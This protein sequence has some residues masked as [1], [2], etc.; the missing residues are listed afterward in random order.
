MISP[1]YKK[2]DLDVIVPGKVKIVK[3]PGRKILWTARMIAFLKSNYSSLSN[4]QLADSLGLSV[5]TVRVQLYKMGMRRMDLVYWTKNQVN[6]L[7]SHYKE[8]GDKEL[9]EIF[10]KKWHKAKVWTHKHIEKKR[11]Y[12]ELKRSKLQLEAIHQRN[13]DS[14]RFLLCPV[15]RWLVSGV[16]AEGEIRFWRQN[17]GRYVPRIKIGG[18]FVFWARWAWEQHH[19][20]IPVGMNVTFN[21]NDPKNLDVSNLILL[22]DA[23]L[24]SKTMHRTSR[25]LSDNYVAGVM[26]VGD[27][28]LRKAIKENPELIESKRIQL[29]INRIIKRHEKQ[30]KRLA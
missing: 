14:G 17:E 5:T 3:H 22:S 4:H 8:I 24:A 23:Q 20:K 19:G 6:Y 9:A 13:V 16:A 25:G 11:S 1:S 7:L 10:N 12:M 29:Q 26:S 27:P 28:E 21:D 18:K 30:D 2:V 15:K